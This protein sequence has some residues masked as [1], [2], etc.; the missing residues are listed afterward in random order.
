MK[1]AL[2]TTAVWATSISET[3]SFA[4]CRHGDRMGTQA[5]LAKEGV[6][7]GGIWSGVTSLWEEIIEMSTYGPGER[8]M[9][10]LKRKKMRAELEEEQG[11][12]VEDGGGSSEGRSVFDQDSGDEAEWLAAFT[13]A[14]ESSSGDDSGQKLDYDGYKL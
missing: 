7:D 1:S 2:V 5:Q 13:A 14:K 8:A 6:D 3:E 12:D 11:A 9:L 4:R 10:K